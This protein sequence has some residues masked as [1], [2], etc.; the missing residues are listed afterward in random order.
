MKS[1][2][3]RSGVLGPVREVAASDWAFADCSKAPFPGTPNPGMR[4][5][6][7]RRLRRCQPAHPGTAAYDRINGLKEIVVARGPH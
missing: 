2:E 3:A 7:H 1:A 4:Q 6:P 5:R